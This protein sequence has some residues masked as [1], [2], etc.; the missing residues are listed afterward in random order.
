MKLQSYSPTLMCSFEVFTYFQQNFFR[1]FVNTLILWLY[2][3][4]DR[5]SDFMHG[6]MPLY[7]LIFK[8]HFNNHTQ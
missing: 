3:A 4:I 8:V 5:C 1:E 7:W 6:C 2:T